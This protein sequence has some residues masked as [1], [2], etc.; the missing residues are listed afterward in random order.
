MPSN[1]KSTATPDIEIQWHA[2]DREELRPMFALA[3]DSEQQLNS[4][5]HLGRV[6]VAVE[7]GAVVG[8]LQL[9]ET[10][11]AN[12]AELKSMAVVDHRQGRGIG[13]A[14]IERA[15]AESRDAGAQTLLVS[16]ATASTGNLRFYQRLG[17]RM[18]RIQR[19][20]FTPAAGYPDNMM[21]DGIPLRDQIWL[22]QAL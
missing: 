18:L 7:D 9:I 22:S 13:R 14:L 8:H 2:S 20:V 10:D 16:T 4:Y 1:D 6:L 11:T 3:E 21:L 12:E 19:D 15:I 5:L 17:F